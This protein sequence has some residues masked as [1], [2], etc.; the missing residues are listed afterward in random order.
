MKF[1]LF[2]ESDVIYQETTEAKWRTPHEPT[3]KP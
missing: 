2:G 3:Y 1:N